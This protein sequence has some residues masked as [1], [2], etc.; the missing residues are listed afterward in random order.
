VAGSALRLARRRAAQ[1][2]YGHLGYWA[3]PAT[4][5]RRRVWAFVMVLACSRHM[6]VR[7]VLVMDQAAWTAAHVEAFAFF[8]GVPRR[9]A[10]QMVCVTRSPD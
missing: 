5:K 9:R 6:F 10:C 7:P 1:I 8:G 4:G 3:D 2:D